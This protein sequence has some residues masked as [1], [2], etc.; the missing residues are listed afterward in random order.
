MEDNSIWK[1][2]IN[3]KYGTEDGGWFTSFHRGSFGVDLWKSI[4]KESDHLKKD[5]MFKLGDGRK[6]RF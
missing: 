4:A 6:I 1:S 3:T 5:C 2:S